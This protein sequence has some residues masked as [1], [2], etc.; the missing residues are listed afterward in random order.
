M[1]HNIHAKTVGWWGQE[2]HFLAWLKAQNATL[3]PPTLVQYQQ[4]AAEIG[5]YHFLLKRIL[6]LRRDSIRKMRG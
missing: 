4:W 6:S 5:L 1:Q 2:F 3:L